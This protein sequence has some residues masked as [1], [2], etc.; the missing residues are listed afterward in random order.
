VR[1]KLP[2]IRIELRIGRDELRVALGHLLERAM[3][4]A[5]ELAG[6]KSGLGIGAAMIVAEFD[7]DGGRGEQLDNGAYLA[8]HQAML[9]HVIEQ[10]NNR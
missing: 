8:P 7:F 3:M 9:G 4:E 1:S 6:P 5:H 2:Q 10:C